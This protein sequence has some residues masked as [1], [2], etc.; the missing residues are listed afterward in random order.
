MKVNIL[1]FKF[2]VYILFILKGNTVTF[3]LTPNFDVLFNKI[4]LFH[5]QNPIT[6]ELHVHMKTDYKTNSISV[7]IEGIKIPD[8]GLYI[9]I[10]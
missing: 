3:E 8:Q 9:A 10:L 6:H 7:Q 4:E 2:H 1:S 5:E